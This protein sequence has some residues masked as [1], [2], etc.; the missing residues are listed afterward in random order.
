MTTNQVT[1]RSEVVRKRREQS[2]QSSPPKIKRDYRQAAIQTQVKS[3]TRSNGRSTQSRSQI[4]N[5]DRRHYDVA[6]NTSRANIR[7]PGI[8]I[9]ALGPRLISAIL[10]GAMVFILLTLFNSPTFKV[11]SVQLS[12]NV[13][14]T[15]ADIISF[16]PFAGQPIFA[17]KPDL[18]K[19]E[20][21]SRFPEIATISVKATLP[22]KLI[23]QITERIPIFV[24]QR[25]DGTAEWVDAHGYKFPIRG[26]V[27]NLVTIYAYGDPPLIQADQEISTNPVEALNTTAIV[28]PEFI[29]PSMIKAITELI[30]LAPQGAS[31]SYDPSY[32]LG[33]NDPRNWKVYFGENTKNITEK[34]L[35]YQAIVDKLTLEGIQPTLI[36]VEYLEAP[37][38]RTQ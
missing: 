16:L 20:L 2:P 11:S 28:Q 25:Q 32:G 27:E 8:T 5:T 17:A 10:I 15:E 9:P 24:W 18:I 36:S 13:R 31:I 26:E 37:F 14:L 4:Y 21:V 19:D 38:Y 12:G 30:A 29:E 35:V 34:L 6:F 7:T 22:N 33:W 3:Q 1:S 23:V